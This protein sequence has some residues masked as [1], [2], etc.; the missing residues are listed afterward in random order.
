VRGARAG[1]GQ[2]ALGP[3]SKHFV[4]FPQHLRSIAVETTRLNCTQPSLE[5]HPTLQAKQLRTQAPSLAQTAQLELNDLIF[6]PAAANSKHYFE[7]AGAPAD[8]GR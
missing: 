6:A 7:G 3:E 5:L 1:R 4:S 2:E 8:G